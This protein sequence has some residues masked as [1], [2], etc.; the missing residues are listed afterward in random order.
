MMRNTP[1]TDMRVSVPSGLPTGPAVSSA[2]PALHATRVTTA[3]HATT[4]CASPRWISLTHH[5]SSVQTTTAP[6]RAAT[7][8]RDMPTRLGTSIQGSVLYLRHANTAT[9]RD[10]R[11]TTEATRRWLNSIRGARSN[12]GTTRPSQ[13]GQ[14]GHPRPEP[15][16]LTTPPRVTWMMATSRAA[17]AR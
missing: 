8:T 14:S 6:S 9:D 12:T 10:R 17:N 3:M 16:T 15:V 2:T 13:R 1:A 7:R 4:P 11:P 5:A